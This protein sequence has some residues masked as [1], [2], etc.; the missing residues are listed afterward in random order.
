MAEAAAEERV[1]PGETKVFSVC[2]HIARYNLA[3]PHCKD[4]NVLD[5]ACGSGYGTHLISKVARKVFGIDIDE[6]S[7]YY[8]RDEYASRR[9]KYE[10][11]DVYDIDRLEYYGLNVLVSFETIE[12]LDD[13]DGFINLCGGF[14]KVIFSV[15][16]N[17]LEGKNPYHKHTYTLEQARRLFGGWR[18]EEEYIQRGVNFY[19]IKYVDKDADNIFYYK[20]VTS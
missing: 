8:A 15:P 12:H 14:N 17:E 3:L 1:V 6:K 5:A 18:V 4:E 2:R 16:L 11:M 9:A 20:V 7:I 19:P 10:I 13:V